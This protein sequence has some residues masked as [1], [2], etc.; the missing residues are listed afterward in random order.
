M[1]RAKKQ[2]AVKLLSSSTAIILLSEGNR[3]GTMSGETKVEGQITGISPM[4]IGYT[5]ERHRN[6]KDMVS[7]LNNVYRV[8]LKLG[9]TK[10]D[11]A[12]SLRFPTTK[13]ALCKA[14]IGE[15]VI[16]TVHDGGS[17]RK[18]F[19]M[20][21]GHVNEI[22][23]WGVANNYGYSYLVLVPHSNIISFGTKTSLR[24]AKDAPVAAKKAAAD[25]KPA[26]RRRR[27][28]AAS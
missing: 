5:F 7:P 25:K 28:K 9:E 13:D 2:D 18:P 19:K 1:A 23:L 8:K 17:V 15:T 6:R 22:G 26:A 11:P 3:A 10:N 20:V 14:M 27:A 21:L 12:A 4:G 24:P 16:V